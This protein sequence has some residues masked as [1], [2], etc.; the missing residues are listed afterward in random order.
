MPILWVKKFN[1]VYLYTLEK[2][3]EIQR[4]ISQAKKHRKLQ[5]DI[6]ANHLLKQKRIRMEQQKMSAKVFSSVIFKYCAYVFVFVCVQILKPT[7]CIM[8]VY[9]ILNHIHNVH[10]WNIHN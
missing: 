5:D 2:W 10:I 8:K 3:N 6:L 7:P 9:N 4:Q 1:V